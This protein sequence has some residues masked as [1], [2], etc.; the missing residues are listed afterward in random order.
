MSSCAYQSP[1]EKSTTSKVACVHEVNP[2]IALSSKVE[3]LS[4]KIDSVLVNSTHPLSISF[5]QTWDMCTGP[6][7][8]HEW[9]GEGTSSRTKEQVNA[10][11]IFGV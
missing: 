2:V 9:R 6:Y 3:L 1:F 10:V 5:S 7:S 8:T 11:G 4:K